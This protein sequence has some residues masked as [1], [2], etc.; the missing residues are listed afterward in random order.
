[1]DSLPPGLPE[2]AVI[3]LTLQV[4][5]VFVWATIAAK[6]IEGGEPKA[7]ADEIIHR[8]F[9]SYDIEGLYT[10]Y[11]GVPETSFGGAKPNEFNFFE[12]VVGAIVF[13]QAASSC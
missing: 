6:F 9:D 8:G 11:S 5:G 1:M 2:Q 10:L 4:A 12:A 13:F 7:R 3:A